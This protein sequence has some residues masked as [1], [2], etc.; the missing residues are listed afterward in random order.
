M[1]PWIFNVLEKFNV[2]MDPFDIN[3]LSNICPVTH[4]NTSFHPSSNPPCHYNHIMFRP[5]LLQVHDA[6]QRKKWSIHGRQRQLDLPHSEP[7]VSFPEGS[8]R[9]LSKYS[10]GRGE[11]SFL[12]ILVICC[13]MLAFSSCPE[14]PTRWPFLMFNF[15]ASISS[16]CNIPTLP[17]AAQSCR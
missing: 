15:L 7:R 2:V 5:L 11:L 10:V 3:Y 1:K 4:G 16:P 12:L 14:N 6:D 8:T 13:V 17:H 9:P